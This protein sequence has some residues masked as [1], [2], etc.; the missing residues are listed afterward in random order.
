MPRQVLRHAFD[1]D[2]ATFSLLRCLLMP[3]FFAGDYAFF[4]YFDA[5]YAKAYA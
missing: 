4:R 1:A 5:R 3:F 2:A